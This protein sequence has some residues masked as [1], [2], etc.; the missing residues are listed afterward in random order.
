MK[1]SYH[2]EEPG[3]NGKIILKRSL[4]CRMEG[5]GFDECGSEQR[6][7]QAAVN[8]VRIIGFHK[9]RKK[10]GSLRYY[11]LLKKEYAPFIYLSIYLFI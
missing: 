4:G 8:T 11:E 7:L 5:C 10:F 3:L 6:Q 2:L 1:Q 9:M